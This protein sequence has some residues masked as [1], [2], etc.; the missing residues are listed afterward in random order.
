MN[1]N[2]NASYMIIHTTTASF[3]V[4]KCDSRNGRVLVRSNCQENLYRFFG[5]LEINMSSDPY[6][7]YEVYAC[8]QEFA[9]AMIIMVK[10]IDYSDFSECTV[11]V[12]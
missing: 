6:Y 11:N 12:A 3:L 2:F 10:E 1:L 4:E 5:S 9:N 7:P 8:K